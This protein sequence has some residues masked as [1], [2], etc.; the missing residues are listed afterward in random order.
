[1]NTEQAFEKQSASEKPGESIHNSVPEQEMEGL[2][3]QSEAFSVVTDPNPY[4][5]SL[6][7]AYDVMDDEGMVTLNGER[8]PF[9]LAAQHIGNIEASNP[10]HGVAEKPEIEHAAEE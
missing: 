3:E 6:R 8:M 9:S 5:E 4:D 7:Q 1:M 10:V 2:T